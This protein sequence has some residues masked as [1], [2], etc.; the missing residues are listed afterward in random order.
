MA[1]F[2]IE[3]NGEIVRAR[4]IDIKV[5]ADVGMVRVNTAII[6][7]NA[8]SS[9][10]CKILKDKS[11]H[12]QYFDSEGQRQVEIIARTESHC[13]YW[14]H[15]NQLEDP[16]GCVIKRVAECIGSTSGDK[17]IRFALKRTCQ[18]I[19]TAAGHTGGIGTAPDTPC[20]RAIITALESVIH[21][22]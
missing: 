8:N 11:E 13:P 2:A 16:I 21:A 3:R 4:G 5:G 20:S 1:V 12:L 22:R 19:Y 15:S 17:I 7:A 18:K 9:T 10:R 6:D 14:F